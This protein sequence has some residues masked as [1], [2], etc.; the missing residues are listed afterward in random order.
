MAIN[1]KPRAL[2]GFKTDRQAAFLCLRVKKAG[3]PR[4]QKNRQPQRL[5]KQRNE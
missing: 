4:S 2:V 5:A 3:V 1:P